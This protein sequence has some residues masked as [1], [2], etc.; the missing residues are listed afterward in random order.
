M[1]AEVNNIPHIGNIVGSHLPADIFAR[2]LRIME[3]EVVF[4]GGTDE[5]GSP[6]EVAAFKEGL[7]PK[8]LC[9]R[10]FKVHKKIYD[11]LGI[12]YDNFSRT[13]TKINHEL[14]KEIFLKLIKKKLIVKKKIL[15]PYCEN[16]KR[17][18]PD[19]WVEGI[20]P[21]C[22]YESARGDQCEACTKLLEPSQLIEPRCVICNRKP[23]FKEVEHLFLDLKKVEKKLKKWIEKNK[24]W[25]KNVRSIALSWIKEGLKERC[26]TRD[27]KWGI[28]VPLKG[29]EDKVFYCWFDAPIGYISSTIEWSIKN[30]K[31]DEWIKF[32]KNKDSKIFHFLG[33]DNIPF[34]T[35]LWPAILIGIGEYNLPYQVVGMEFLNYEGRKI[36]KS[37]NWGIFLDVENE[38]VVVKIGEK[39]IKLNP[40][41]LRFYLSYI[42]PE[43]KDSNFS[44]ED[45]KNRVNGELVDNFGNL[46]YRVLT[47]IKTRFDSRVP[48]SKE[49]NKKDEK[50]LKEIKKV[51][52][53]VKKK[54]LNLNFKDALKN[55][56]QLSD[57]GNKYFQE[58][59]PWKEFSKDLESCKATLFV[60][61]CLVK[62]LAILL[63]P[64]IPFSSE[65][66][67]NQLN[68]KE[69]K[70][71]NVD[72]FDLGNHL[73]GE[74][75]PIFKKLEAV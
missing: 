9:D 52:E 48:I 54:I 2:F 8:E 20:C 18:L 28:K 46:A 31:G 15:L 7:E 40:D 19:R 36:S 69:I 67:L 50:V 11:W 21:Y 27:L 24:H 64:F 49:L 37:K 75:E 17:F 58:K 23:I 1:M 13:S 39:N 55:I 32:W 74:I 51:K 16:D 5:H 6:T 10:L 57:Y 72:K 29:F 66:V 14:T 43:T 56:L 35:I 47:F 22:N 26:I 34:H 30:G 63:Y 71:E 42:M 45:F 68:Y 60:S 25:K 4:V 33:K 38:E 73:I 65:K 61:A 53:N 3:E 62:A 41:F 59:S 44:L 12:S 70:F